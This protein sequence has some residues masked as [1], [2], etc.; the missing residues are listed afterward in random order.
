MVT[1]EG[2][3]K[4]YDLQYTDSG[5]PILTVYIGN[6]DDTPI[7][8]KFVGGSALPYVEGIEEVPIDT[9]A[10]AYA[11]LNIRAYN[12][13]SYI[14]LDGVNFGVFNEP[15]DFKTSGALMA[16]VLDVQEGRTKNG[17]PFKTATVQPYLNARQELAP[18]VEMSV[19]NI[20]TPG[21][22]TIL[23]T[24]SARTYNDKIYLSLREFTSSPVSFKAIQQEEAVPF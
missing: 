14:N 23:F 1:I 12:G 6:K 18:T 7:P 11:T 16:Q 24:V 15:V 4:G 20:D 9:P 2:L 21:V 19:K 17:K 10:F 8:I 22:Y 5:T 3:F 13:K